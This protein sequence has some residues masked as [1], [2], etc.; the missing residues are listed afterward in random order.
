MRY[1]VLGTG[2]VGRTI[3]AALAERRH[4]VMIGTRDPQA[5]LRREGAD[6]MGNPPFA[7]W[8]KE[9][10]AVRLGTFAQAAAHG[11][12]IVNATL[13]DGTL[14][15]LKE[16][17]EA[18]LAGKVLL[19]IS[20]PL[21]FSKGMPPTLTVSNTDSLAEQLQRAFPKAKVVKSLNTVTA[22]VMVNPR[23]VAEGDHTIFLSGNDLGAKE[24]VAALLRSFGWRD[25]MDLGDITSARG[26]E[27]YLPLWLR[28]WG[29]AKT[30][31]LNIKVAR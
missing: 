16:A 12:L 27:M 2:V 19:D 22:R 30:P 6:R 21:D 20:N 1:G 18:N 5:T 26:Q 14:A 17:G 23:S 10:P 25:V 8:Q 24:T 7:Q 28:L 29:A 15:A 3:A 31:M 4:E 11:E 13:G 9:H